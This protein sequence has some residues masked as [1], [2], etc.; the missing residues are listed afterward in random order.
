[1]DTYGVDYMRTTLISYM[2]P[3][4]KVTTKTAESP[5][6]YQIP[7][8]TVFDL[9]KSFSHKGSRFALDH[10]QLIEDRCTLFKPANVSEDE[11]KRKFLYVSLDDEARSWMRSINEETILGWE[12]M[13]KSFY[14]KYYAPIEAYHGRGLI[15]NFWPHP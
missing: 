3:A 9:L 14:L 13:K 11:A 7:I 4:A 1:M 10:L 15:Y 5:K 2:Y 12:D 8:N 6:E